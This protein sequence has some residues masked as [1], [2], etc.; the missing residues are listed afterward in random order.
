MSVNGLNVGVDFNFGLFDTNSQ[1][2]LALGDVQSVKETAQKHDIK[3]MPYN[4]PPKFGYVPD[5][6]SGTFAITRTG[7][8]MEKLQITLQNNFN[9]GVPILAG[10][11]NKIV[12]DSGVVTKYQY[13]GVTFFLSD[14]GDISREK[15]VTQTMVWMASDKQQ[16]A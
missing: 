15:T 4:G 13:T 12:N 2:V 6:Y 11:L 9:N 1:Q 8:Q 7:S 5:G 3:S 14:I 16:L 10:F